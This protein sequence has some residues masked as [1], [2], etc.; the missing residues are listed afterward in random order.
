MKLDLLNED[1]GDVTFVKVT[2]D[3]VLVLRFG[4][5]VEHVK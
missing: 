2:S 1:G 3:F 4:V 5:L